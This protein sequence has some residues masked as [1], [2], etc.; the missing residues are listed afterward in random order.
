MKAIVVTGFG[1]TE[2]MVYKEVETPS[3][4]ED[5]VLIRV[6]AAS[7]N[8]ADIK[9]RYGQKGAS[10]PYIPGLDAAGVVEKTGSGVRHLKPGQRVIAFPANGSYSEYAAADAG[11]TFA[12]PDGIDLETAA[13]CPIV[14]FLSH[15][16]LA[17]VARLERGETVLVHSAAGGV[18]TTAVRMAKLLGAGRVIGTVGD[19]AKASAALE[20]GADVVLH[21]TEAFAREVLDLTEGEGAHVILDSL[22]GWVTEES[23]RCLAPYGRLV[24]FGNAGGEPGTI[25]T[26]DLHASCRSVL[27]Y[28]FGTTRRRRPG[29]LQHT[30]KA[31]LPMLADGRLTMRIGARFALA[32]AAEAHALV[33]SR[34]S[35]GKVLLD[36]RALR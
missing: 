15:Q 36:L 13:A 16:L 30:A 5:Q 14:S 23:M 7:V 4:G 22:A 28:S 11:L 33:E 20:A 12:L 24:H 8:Y 9:A 17:D 32:D 34:R 26:P 29:I 31:V 3:I 25:R 10:L 27:G 19:P 18:G 21:R 1:G 35:T 2:H 6:A